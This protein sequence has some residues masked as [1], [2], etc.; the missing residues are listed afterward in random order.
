MKRLYVILLLICLSVTMLGCEG[1]PAVTPADTSG[2]ADTSDTANT[3]D[4][5]TLPPET[6]LSISGAAY[7]I[8]RPDDGSAVRIS[9][10]RRLL[11]YIGQ[12]TGTDPDIKVDWVK[13]GDDPD[14]V[15]QYEILIGDTNRSQSSEV[16]CESGWYVGVHDSKLVILA[17]RDKYYSAAV[18]Y[19]ISQFSAGEDGIIKIMKELK[20]YEMVADVYAGVERTLR[21]GSYN[22]RHGGDVALDMSVIAADIKALKLDVVGL[23]EVDQLTERV[24]GLDTMKA[25][26]E[27]S[28][29][30]YY[31]F[32]H[33]INYRGGEYGTAILSRYPID[34]FEVI[35]LESGTLEKRSAG[36]AII[37]VD[38]VKFDFFNTHLSHEN[39]GIRAGQIAQLAPILA[40]CE[41]YI[42]T[43][44]FNTS[45]IA[46]FSAWSEATFVNRGKYPTFTPS[47]SSIDNIMLAGGWSAVEV[48]MGPEGHSDHCMLW[49]ELRFER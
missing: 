9:A 31:A 23:Q 12:C 41:T 29:Y 18:D 33:A 10:A 35:P 7:T 34:S 11:E 27:A 1:T 48:G 20:H 6:M 46:E 24:G 17:S 40:E 47:A 28:G 45:S 49:A 16:Q 22:I 30:Q 32:A 36:H 15:S 44:D 25:L 8:V 42:V 13:P 19:L 39:A 3:P 38:G 21:V 2:T 4:S 26:S 14:A 37:D 43:G 5:S